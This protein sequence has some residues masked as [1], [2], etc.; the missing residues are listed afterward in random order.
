MSLRF[1]PRS[2]VYP[3]VNRMVLPSGDQELANWAS[4]VA[5]VRGS[6]SP[7]PSAFLTLS[8]GIASAKRL[9]ATR[10]PS[11]DQVAKKWE[12]GSGVSVVRM[13]RPRS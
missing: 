8:V 5:S 10:R 11:G 3:A 1:G 6:I 12:P 9:K 2:A 7:L 4:S 13:F